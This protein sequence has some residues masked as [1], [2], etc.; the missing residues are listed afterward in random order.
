MNVMRKLCYS[1]TQYH[2]VLINIYSHNTQ[3]PNYLDN[4]KVHFFSWN[5]DENLHQYFKSIKI[6][7]VVL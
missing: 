7:S 2:A 1:V 6:G 5:L 4:S 3:A